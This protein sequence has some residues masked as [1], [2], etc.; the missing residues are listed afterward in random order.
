M[1]VGFQSPMK[2]YRLHTHVLF[3]S[4]AFLMSWF[5]QRE[6]MEY[7][8]IWNNALAIISSLLIITWFIN[9]FSDVGEAIQTCF[10]SEREIEPNYGKMMGLHE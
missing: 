6:R 3:V 9:I 5:I 7:Y 1:F 8:G 2:N 4:A 10:L